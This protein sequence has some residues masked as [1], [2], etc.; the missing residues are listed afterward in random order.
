MNILRRL[1]LCLLP[2]AC[3]AG[4]AQE[5][6]EETNGK[7][8]TTVYLFGMAASFNDSIV[9]F[10]TVQKVDSAWMSKK[11]KFLLGR[12]NYSHQLRQYLA[13]SMAM[14]HR[15][16]WLFFSSKKETMEKKR[17]KM[18][19]L[20]TVGKKKKK[21]SAKPYYQAVFL[22]DE[23]FHY[24]AVYMGDVEDENDPLVV[25]R[26]K[27]ETKRQKAEKKAKEKANREAEKAWKKERKDKK[28]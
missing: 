4:Q 28:G 11:S 13:D 24:Q 1:A 27:A 8:V 5:A 19:R 15:T 14:P 25:A 10:T 7:K 23:D 18:I 2:F 16:A 9:H 6:Q 26:K 21:K 3:L 20:Y 22:T 17:D 12:E